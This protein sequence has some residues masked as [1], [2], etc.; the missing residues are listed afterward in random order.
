MPANPSTQK[1]EPVSTSAESKADLTSPNPASTPESAQGADPQV[2]ATT[3][4]VAPKG[5]QSVTFS[6]EGVTVIYDDG[7][8]TTMTDAQFAKSH[9]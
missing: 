9:I 1:P 4:S 7:S 6:D 8:S 3:K 5:V 2:E